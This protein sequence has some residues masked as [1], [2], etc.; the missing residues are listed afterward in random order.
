MLDV[1]LV[2]A[3]QTLMLRHHCVVG[4]ALNEARARAGDIVGLFCLPV[5]S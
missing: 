5:L 1:V 3:A 4:E 2:Y